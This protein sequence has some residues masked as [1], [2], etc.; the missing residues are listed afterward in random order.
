MFFFYL[1]SVRRLWSSAINLLRYPIHIDWL[2][3]FY[4]RTEWQNSNEWI[5]SSDNIYGYVRVSVWFNI[6]IENWSSTISV[7]IIRRWVL[8]WQYYNIS[9]KTSSSSSSSSCSV[10]VIINII[11]RHHIIANSKDDMQFIILFD[12]LYDHHLQ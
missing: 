11:E 12:Y 8:N 3:Q 10:H 7:I 5:E 1:P 6:H 9:I 4:K 2:I